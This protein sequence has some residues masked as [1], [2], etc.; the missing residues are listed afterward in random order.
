M[1]IS[2]KKYTSKC[3]NDF[4]GVRK[5][6]RKEKKDGSDIVTGVNHAVASSLNV[7]KKE[8]KKR[9]MTLT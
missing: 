4:N 3:I 6:E 1:F 2:K 8:R 5:K 9:K 7:C